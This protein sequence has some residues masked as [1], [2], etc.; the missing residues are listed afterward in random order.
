MVNARRESSMSSLRSFAQLTR[1]RRVPSKNT[2]RT[3]QMALAFLLLTPI[4]AAAQQSVGRA[5]RAP[6]NLPV[7]M[8]TLAVVYWLSKLLVETMHGQARKW[9][10]ENKLRFV[11][12]VA[13]TTRDRAVSFVVENE[14]GL[15]RTGSLFGLSAIWSQASFRWDDEWCSAS[16]NRPERRSRDGD[17]RR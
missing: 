3:A 17:G 6:R 4:H 12:F 2:S 7:F 13:P 15:R 10:T 5:S 8:V 9:A 14:A 1:F 11:E 16:E